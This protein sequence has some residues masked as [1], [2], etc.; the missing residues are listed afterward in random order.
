MVIG[1]FFPQI[2]T[3]VHDFIFMHNISIQDRSVSAG[4]ILNL[5]MKG[6]DFSLSPFINSTEKD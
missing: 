2:I 6:K 4:I 1:Y 5:V 3:C